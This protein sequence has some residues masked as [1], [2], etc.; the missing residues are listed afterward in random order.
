LL[1]PRDF[2]T[3]IDVN[4]APGL[5][6][7]FLRTLRRKPLA[8]V[9][10]SARSAEF[11]MRQS[12]SLKACPPKNG[13]M[14]LPADCRRRVLDT[15]CATVKGQRGAKREPPR[16]PPPQ[17]KLVVVA[18]HCV[19]VALDEGSRTVRGLVKVLELFAPGMT[20]HSTRCAMSISARRANC[21][22]RRATFTMGRNCFITQG[23]RTVV[24][25]S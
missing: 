1:S 25:A 6:A 5:K 20:S 17:K 7:F 19:G 16:C 3:D 11:Q 18:C 4:C 8:R 24:L 2:P 15:S 23:S 13:G 14:V 12:A 22:T 21:C 9:A 10:S